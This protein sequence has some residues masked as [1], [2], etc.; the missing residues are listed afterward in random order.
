MLHVEEN[1]R[2]SVRDGEWRWLPGALGS[3]GGFLEVSVCDFEPWFLGLELDEADGGELRATDNVMDAAS[4]SV[5][6]ICGQ[7]ARVSDSC[8]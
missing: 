2:L 6:V 7:R 4:D 3:G 1:S 8:R 5:S